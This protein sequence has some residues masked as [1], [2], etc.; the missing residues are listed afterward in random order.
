[1]LS[2]AC[3]QYKGLKINEKSKQFYQTEFNNLVESNDYTWVGHCVVTLIRNEKDK[4]YIE[5]CLA[6]PNSREK[7]PYELDDYKLCNIELIRKPYPDSVME[8]AL[9]SLLTNF[10]NITDLCRKIVLGTITEAQI[11]GS[12]TKFDSEKFR[13]YLKNCI[14]ASEGKLNM[15][16]K[17]QHEA[18][19]TAFSQEFSL[20]QGL[21]ILKYLLKKIE[22]LISRY[23]LLLYR[24]TSMCILTTGDFFE[25]RST[26]YRKNN[27]WS[28]LV[29]LFLSI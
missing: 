8:S 9:R 14:E 18:M 15:P 29:S 7:V 25:N 4:G 10:K 6:F 20:I 2:F 21:K 22:F 1:M 11:K 13:N 26:R 23:R 16:N 3:I 17:K 27:Y 12:Q 24:N 5:L 28:H 19:L